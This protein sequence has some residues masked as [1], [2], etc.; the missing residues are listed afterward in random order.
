MIWNRRGE[1]ARKIEGRVNMLMYFGLSAATRGSFQTENSDDG[2]K[3]GGT[4]L[5]KR[6]ARMSG[7]KKNAAVFPVTSLRM[8]DAITGK[9]ISWM[10]TR[11]TWNRRGKKTKE[12]MTFESFCKRKKEIKRSEYFQTWKLSDEK[13]NNEMGLSMKEGVN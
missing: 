7:K 1:S 13:K 6:A 11:S 2:R 5:W 8:T 12:R 10:E 4:L 3:K 9:Q